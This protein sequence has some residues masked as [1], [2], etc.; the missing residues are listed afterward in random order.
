M[1]L[2]PPL[3]T[4]DS[5]QL[6]DSDSTLRIVQNERKGG[7]NYLISTLNPLLFVTKEHLPLINGIVANGLEN[8]KGLFY[9]VANLEDG[10]EEWLKWII[11]E[12]SVKLRQNPKWGGELLVLKREHRVNQDGVSLEAL[13]SGIA[14]IFIDS[15]GIQ[16]TDNSIHSIIDLTLGFNTRIAIISNDLKRGRRFLDYLI[17]KRG[18][19]KIEITDE[20]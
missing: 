9:L 15:M 11:S 14:V 5:Q 19:T 17:A 7:Y 18:D 3:S 16:D 6:A 8:A 1:P 10:I 2:P 4:I 13:R 12:D 20:A